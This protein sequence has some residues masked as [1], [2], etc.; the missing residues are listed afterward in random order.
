M[1]MFNGTA[2]P[3]QSSLSIPAGFDV[4]GFE[5]VAKENFVKLQKAWDTG[6]VIDISDFTTNDRLFYH[7]P[8]TGSR[9]RETNLRS[10]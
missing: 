6:N 4:T 2:E 5:K 7:A 3:E 1:D 9:Q 10:D 8:V